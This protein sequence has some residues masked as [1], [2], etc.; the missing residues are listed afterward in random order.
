[1]CKLSHSRPGPQLAVRA[2]ALALL[3]APPAWADDDVAPLMAEPES[4]WVVGMAAS[5][6]QDY[7]GAGQS[8]WKLRPLWAWQ[9]GRYRISTSR[10]SAVLGFGGE[11]VGSGASAQLV[12]SDR[13]KV[14]AS[15]RFDTG[16]KASD[17]PALAGL[18]DVRRTLRGR[19]SASWVLAPHW[20]LSGGLSQDLLGRE[21]GAIATLD[22]GTGGRL[23]VSSEWSAGVGVTLANSQSMRS[24]FGVSQAAALASGLPAY[25]AR[26]GIKDLH[27]GLG[28]T[29]ALTPRWVAFGGVGISRLQGDAARSPLTHAL[30]GSSASVGLAYRCC[31]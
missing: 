21:G 26:G 23:G 13:L 14:G 31:R 1:M 10:G 24:Y 30:T 2:A 25:D 29:T 3:I 7:A 5:H 16:R 11:A 9:R 6:A 28:F 20:S 8:Q 15:L 27:A 18:P 12:E 17:S 19:V 22:L 4:R